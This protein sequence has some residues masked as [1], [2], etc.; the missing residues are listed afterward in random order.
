MT[1][2]FRLNCSWGL[3]TLQQHREA[4]C[5]RLGIGLCV[6]EF[7]EQILKLFAGRYKELI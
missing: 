4:L 3:S 1:A 2:A 6:S 7:K 5:D